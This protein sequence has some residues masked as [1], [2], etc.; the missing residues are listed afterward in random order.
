M[1]GLGVLGL[2]RGLGSRVWGFRGLP[3]VSIVVAFW[4]YL[5]GS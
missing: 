2:G 4:G 1:L 3:S 5:L